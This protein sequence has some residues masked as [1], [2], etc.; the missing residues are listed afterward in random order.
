MIDGV[1]VR[2]ARPEDRR[3]LLRL[4]ALDS[5]PEPAGAWLVADVEGEAWAALPLSGG[6]AIADPFRHTADL[7]ALLEVRAAQLQ[8]GASSVRAWRRSSAVTSSWL[9]RA[10]ALSSE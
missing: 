3:A 5:A 9:R 6:G 4:A 7:V 2:L 1:S 8:A 10:L